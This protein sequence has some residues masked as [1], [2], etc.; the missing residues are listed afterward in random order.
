MPS[1]AKR[2]EAR[3]ECLAAE[4]GLVW[5]RLWCCERIR[6]PAQISAALEGELDDVQLVHPIFNIAIP[7]A[8]PC[9]NEVLNPE[10]SWEP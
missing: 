4:Y 7:D 8:V 3:H 6:A 9:S 2:L 5:W 10:L 1:L